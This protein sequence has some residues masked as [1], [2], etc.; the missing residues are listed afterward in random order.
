VVDADRVHRLLRGI[1]LRLHELDAERS[2]DVDVRA[3]SRWLNSVK[4]LFVTAI[5]GCLDV[6]HHLVASEGWGTPDTNASAFL[7]LGREGVLSRDLAT[8]MASAVG[9]RNVLVHQ[10]ATVDDD[11]VIEFLDQLDAL[12]AFVAAVVKWLDESTST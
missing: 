10:Y 6:A 11:R 1:D 3:S 7:V 9:F 2:A 8:V 5:E 4:Y 12:R